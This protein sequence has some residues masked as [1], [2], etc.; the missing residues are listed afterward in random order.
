MR[1]RV[2]HDKE[3]G[4]AEEIGASYIPLDIAGGSF[5]EEPTVVPKAL[6]LC[7]EHLGGKR[8]HYARDRWIARSATP[9]KPRCSNCLPVRR[10]CTSYMQPKPRT[11]RSWRSPIGVAG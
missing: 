1:R 3:T 6:F 11:E 10:S 2:L 5:L 8:Y 9:E 4:R 7:V